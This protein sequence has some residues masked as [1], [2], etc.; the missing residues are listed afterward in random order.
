MIK[1]L[2]WLINIGLYRPKTD[3][4]FHYNHIPF[5]FAVLMIMN[6]TKYYHISTSFWVFKIINNKN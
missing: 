2:K 4:T 5:S 6:I 3:W 1:V